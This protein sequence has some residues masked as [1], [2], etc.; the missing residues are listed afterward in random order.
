[1]CFICANQ[2]LH[3]EPAN[4]AGPVSRYAIVFH[5]VAWLKRQG[6]LNQQRMDYEGR[7]KDLKARILGRSRRH[8]IKHRATRSFHETL[9]R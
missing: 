7:P 6:L 2:W 4:S 1:M 5:T 8:Y 3:S 9:E